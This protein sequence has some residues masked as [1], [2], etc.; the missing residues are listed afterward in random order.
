[1]G[2]TIG[3]ALVTF[4]AGR[5]GDTGKT[6]DAKAL[7]VIGQPPLNVNVNSP[8]ASNVNLSVLALPDSKGITDLATVDDML[9]TIYQSG[10]LAQS[11]A[12]GFTFAKFKQELTA[13]ISGTTQLSLQVGDPDPKQA[14][15][16]VN[17]WAQAV[18][19]RLN[20]LYGSS[21]AMV[22]ALEKQT[23]DAQQK[24]DAAEQGLLDYLPQ[25]NLDALMAQLT[26][27]QIAYN[28]QLGRIRSIDLL[29][30][31]G[32]AL[33]GRLG[34][35]QPGAA[36]TTGD[37][38][39]LLALQQRANETLLCNSQS[40]PDVASSTD[41][42]PTGTNQLFVCATSGGSSGLQVQVSGT[43]L[44]AGQA[45][46]ADAQQN[47][48]SFMDALAS[49]QSELKN[50]LTQTEKQLAG[51]RAQSESAQ[52]HVDQLTQQ[53]DLAETAFK[54]L[55]NQLS[56]VRGEVAAYGQVARIAGQ[57]MPPTSASSRRS[58]LNAIVA[59]A[60]AFILSVVAIYLGE[61]WRSSAAS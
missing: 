29:L 17:L 22:T 60:L 41:T 26:Q 13:S 27:E 32:G 55:S 51:I 15:L 37:A 48:K 59:G 16:V 53:R 3:A 6:Y 12:H 47:L 9:Y 18:T 10:D 33:N 61:W 34:A 36:L 52:F 28:S 54:I 4:L 35:R 11:R 56:S 2:I 30:S 49:Q 1:M 20:A 8:A 42:N 46:V 5:L 19:D 14:A 40:M 24:W 57:A 43:D 23:N 39:S 7:V 38:L 25:S 44:L 45:T 50:G 58:L 31:D 21:S